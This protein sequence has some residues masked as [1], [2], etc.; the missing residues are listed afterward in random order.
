MSE[1]RKEQE[2]GWMDAIRT[3]KGDRCTYQDRRMKI[4]KQRLTV[5]GVKADGTAL[6]GRLPGGEDK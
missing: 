6:S 2:D 3:E 1:E 5:S 4:E